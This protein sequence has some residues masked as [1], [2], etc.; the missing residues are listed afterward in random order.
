VVA[1]VLPT[2]QLQRGVHPLTDSDIDLFHVG[3]DGIKLLILI[4]EVMTDGDS[5]SIRIVKAVR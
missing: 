4:T 2:S 3:V 5:V 1:P